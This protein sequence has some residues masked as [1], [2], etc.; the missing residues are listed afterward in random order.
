MKTIAIF[1]V[2]LL[3]AISAKAQTDSIGVF[4]VRNGV[5]NRI[6]VLNYN[7][8][9]ISG[10]FRSKAKLVFEGATSANRFNGSAT[11]RLYFGTPSPYDA[12][13]YYM[14]TPSYSAKD[15]NVG[16]FDVK[17]GNRYLTT[18]SVSI[19]GSKL[20]AGKAK[21]V[22]VEYKQL[23]NNVYEITVTGPA[24]EYCI[25]S[26]R[27]GVAGYTGVFDFTIE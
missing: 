13:K 12:A 8:T 15:F 14:F 5:T 20:G 17:K 27:N 6:E 1:I 22:N 18:V 24:G 26:V 19:I 25:M 3:A 11:F 10:G 4:S 9:K 16:R 7:Q 21:D 23:R 2:A